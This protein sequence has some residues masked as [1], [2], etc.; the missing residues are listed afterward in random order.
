[1]IS[2]LNQ[3]LLIDSKKKVQPVHFILAETGLSIALIDTKTT[4]ATSP[5][6]QHFIDLLNFPEFETAFETRLIPAINGCIDS[7]IQNNHQEF[8]AFMKQLIRFQLYHFRR[9]IPW[10]F[11][12]IISDAINHQVFIKLL[13]SGG[14]GFLL[15]FAENEKILKGWSDRQKI[16][17]EMVV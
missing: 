4:G 14:G 2:F 8:F 1:L 17:M 15:A 6:V 5:M 10:N 12:P 7:L 11:Q 9:M 3:P 16:Q 13:G